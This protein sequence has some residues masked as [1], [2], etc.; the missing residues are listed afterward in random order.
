MIHR[1]FLVVTLALLPSLVA[2]TTIQDFDGPGTGFAVAKSLDSFASGSRADPAVTGGGP[3]DNFLRLIDFR[4]RFGRYRTGL[5]FEQT[6]GGPIASVRATF[7]F[8]MTCA[9]ARGGFS[10]GGCGDGFSINFLDTAL[11]GTSGARIFDEF[12]RGAI[13]ETGTEELTTEG[14]FSVGFGTFG[15][16]SSG[17]NRV[18]TRFDN[19]QS[20][21][22]ANLSPSAIDLATGLHSNFGAFHHAVIDLILAGTPMLS[23]TL[24][25]GTDGSM[26]TVFDELDLSGISGL[27]P[28]DMRVNFGARVGDAGMTIDLDNIDVTFSP[29]AVVPEP[30]S[31]AL[32]AA[33]VAALGASA[34]RRTRAARR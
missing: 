9:G 3:D 32:A 11:A 19:T 18:F 1:H 30:A 23:L 33:G 8:R 26:H 10:G 21:G 20:A 4:D 25:D 22:S 15:T 12:G 2:A 5:G 6:A 14:A 34:S 13:F 29:L 24:T 28:Y 16:G 31:L 17:S 7:D 27:S